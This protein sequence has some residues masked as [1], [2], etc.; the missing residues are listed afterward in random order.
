MIP[1]TPAEIG[2]RG[3]RARVLIVDDSAMSRQLMH[4]TLKNSYDVIEATDGLQ[5][6]EILKT[7]DTIECVVTDD[8]MPGLSG[9]DV[10]KFVSTL[11]R[12]VPVVMVTAGTLHPTARQIES[13]KAG[14]AAL[15]YKPFT[16]DQLRRFIDTLV[17]G[18]P[19]FPLPK[20]PVSP[21]ESTPRSAPV[22]R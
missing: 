12:R 16:G 13:H 9:V 8:Q 10:A 20:R 11:P 3:H 6:T 15:L 2:T 21:P 4:I 1:S 18:Q 17:G 22:G 7:D 5:A 14:V 19:K